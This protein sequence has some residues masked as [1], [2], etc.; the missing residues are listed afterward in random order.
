MTCRNLPAA[1]WPYDRRMELGRPNAELAA[2]VEHALAMD[3]VRAAA[4]Y[5]AEHGAGFAL[6]CR[7]LTEPLRRRASRPQQERDEPAALP[8][9]GQSLATPHR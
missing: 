6:T 9:P 4:A 8:E 7:V 2:A 1:C 3:D 5:L